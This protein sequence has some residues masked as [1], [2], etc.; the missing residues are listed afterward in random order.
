M[1]EHNPFVQFSS[2]DTT[3]TYSD[4]KTDEKQREYITIYFETP[5]EYGFSSM[6]IRYPNGTP[7]HVVG[8]SEEELN[9]IMYYYHKLGKVAFEF[10]KEGD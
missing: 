5:S 8:Y 1:L 6:N 7:T 4:V 3:I 2:D 9:R 10:A